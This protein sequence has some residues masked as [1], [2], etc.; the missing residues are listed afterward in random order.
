MRYNE[1]NIEVIQEALEAS[2]EAIM[3]KPN[4]MFYC[5]MLGGERFDEFAQLGSLREV[6][7][8]MQDKELR[9]LLSRCREG[10]RQDWP[11]EAMLNAYYAM[12]CSIARW[13][14][15]G[16]IWRPIRR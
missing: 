5:S 10:G 15:C 6:I 9:H 4:L 7:E 3:A 16:A 13:R 12:I 2:G 1:P 11:V 14:L 8:H